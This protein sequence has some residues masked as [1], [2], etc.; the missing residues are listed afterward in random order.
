MQLITYD[1]DGS[2]S[3]IEVS[4]QV[5]GVTYNPDL[6]HQV[7]TAYLAGSRAGTKAQ[8]NRSLVSGGNSKP[9]RQKGTGRARA[10]S[11]RSP[12][13]RGGGK[14]FPACP[15]DYSQKVNRKMYRGAICSVLSELVRQNRLVVVS[16]L[17]VIDIKTKFLLSKLQQ[18]GVGND[19]LIVVDKVDHFLQL[20]ARNLPN[21][22]VVTVAEVNPVS[23]VVFDKI[24]LVEPAVQSLQ[25]RLI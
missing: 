25:E 1:E 15:R 2:Q 23:L 3:V 12:L 7:V 5:F 10:G 14:I 22:D 13:W 20:S 17:T 11:T 16:K 8:K 19:V 9:Y 6:I 4:D 18:L 24:L 21:V